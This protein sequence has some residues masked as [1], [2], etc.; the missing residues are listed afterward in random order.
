MT[1]TEDI[2]VLPICLLQGELSDTYSSNGGNFDQGQNAKNCHIW[3]Y[4]FTYA[5][6]VL[7]LTRTSEQIGI[8]TVDLLWSNFQECYALDNT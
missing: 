4:F 1:T 7:A 3:H 5:V 8:S 6:Y 2:A